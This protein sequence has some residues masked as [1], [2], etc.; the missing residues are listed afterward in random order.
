MPDPNAALELVERFHGALILL[1][2][3]DLENVRNRVQTKKDHPPR[4]FAIVRNV[5]ADSCTRRVAHSAQ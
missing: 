2:K 3:F 5:L 1:Q 4:E